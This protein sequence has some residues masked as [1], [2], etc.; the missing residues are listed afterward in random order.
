MEKV[1]LIY[2]LLNYNTRLN[3]IMIFLFLPI[4]PKVGIIWANSP[5]LHINRSA[6]S[7]VEFY[8]GVNPAP[9]N[10]QFYR[11]NRLITWLKNGVPL[12][13]KLD[14]RITKHVSAEIVIIGLVKITFV[15][16]SKL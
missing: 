7:M 2:D 9:D 6:N 14:D 15:S 12:P 4:A 1:L 16:L 11:H 3:C 10:D 5:A 8:C 13:S